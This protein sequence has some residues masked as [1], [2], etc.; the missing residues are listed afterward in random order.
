MKIKNFIY[1][2]T[3]LTSI[4]SCNETLKA[5]TYWIKCPPVHKVTFKPTGGG[6]YNS[7]GMT[8]TNNSQIRPR[9]VSDNDTYQKHARKFEKIEFDGY[10]YCFYNASP[11][12]YGLILVSYPDYMD[13]KCVPKGCPSESVDKCY[14]ECS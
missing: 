14:L 5:N 13:G 12:D 3:V 9:K 2:S 11:T 1:F 8:T 7:E 4:F 10:I 6:Q